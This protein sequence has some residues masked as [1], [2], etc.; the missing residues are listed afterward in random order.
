MST[1]ISFSNARIITPN[2]ILEGQLCCK[3]NLIANITS[4]S[5][6][7]KQ[8][9]DCQGDFLAPGLIELHTDNLEGH[10][11]PRP[12]VHWPRR[13]AILAH[14]AELVGVGITTVLDALRVG[15]IVSRKDGDY[16]PYAREVA[17]EIQS[18]SKLGVLKARHH[19][20]LRAEI[21]SETLIDEIGS[22]DENDDVR[23]ISMMDHTPGQRQFRNLDKFREYLQ[24][25]HGMSPAEVD[26]HF[27]G[28]YDLQS[29]VGEPHARAIAE[30][31][32]TYN[33]PLASHDDATKDDVI[34]SITAGATLAE[35]PTTIEAATLCREANQSI[36]MGA[37]NLIRGGSHSGNVAAHDLA[38][39]DMLD[40]LSSDYVPASL[41]M[42]AWKLS[43]Q[44]GDIPK[45]MRTVTFNPASALGLNDR[46]ALEEGRKADLV[47]FRIIDNIPQVVSVYVNAQRVA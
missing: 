25:K 46:G 24:G 45:A 43:Q 10:L 7:H 44:L 16:I 11:Q 17:T 47:R 36:I 13:A 20:H 4:N 30:H 37:P 39:L 38:D 14:D 15:S 41:L 3:D 35:F 9:I 2:H 22:F 32:K 42:S 19:L 34:A 8:S 29:K 26:A 23:M 6:E 5:A 27:Q 18:M 21:C 40:I 1:D 33:V 12:G 31:A 28:L